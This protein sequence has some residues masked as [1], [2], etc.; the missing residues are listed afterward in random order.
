LLKAHT[1]PE[2][3]E[4]AVFVIVNQLNRGAELV[5]SED[6]RFQLAELNLIAGK[7]ATFTTSSSRAQRNG[8]VRI[9]SF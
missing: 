3:R 5:T 8:V 4:E 6:E 1:P 9:P 2:K 7:R